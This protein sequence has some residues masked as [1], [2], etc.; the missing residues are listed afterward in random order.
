MLENRCWRGPACWITVV[1]VSGPIIHRFD[2]IIELPEVT[3]D[4]LLTPKISET[5]HV[6]ANRVATAQAYAATRPKQGVDFANAQLQSGQL[7]EIVNFDVYAAR[8]LKTAIE[9]SRLSA[10]PIIKSIVW[11][12]PSP[13]VTLRLQLAGRQFLRRWLTG[14]CR[15]WR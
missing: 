3:S 5:S 8:S 12:A 10:R 4:M 14:Q 11:P 7:F 9:H 6:I 15:Y 1:P 13:I 2:L